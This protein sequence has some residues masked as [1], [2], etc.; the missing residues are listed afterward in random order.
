MSSILSQSLLDHSRFSS[1]LECIGQ[2]ND[3]RVNRRKRHEL[4]AVL[5][6]AVCAMLGGAN[7]W[8]AVELFGKLHVDWL[9]QLVALPYGVPSHDTFNRV[10]AGL[11]HEELAVWLNVWLENVIGTAGQH[12]A[13]DGKILKALNSGNALTIVRAWAKQN[14]ITLA[15][16]RVPKRTNEIRALP[17]VLAQLALR[18]KIVTIDAI[19]TQRH[20]V[21]QIAAQGGDYVLAVK[22]NQS[23]LYWNVKLFLNDLINGEFPRVAHS[24][25]KTYDEGHGRQEL[26]EC[27]ATEAVGWYYRQHDWP[28]LRSI[29]VLQSTRTVKQ[30]TAVTRRY[31]I[32][33]LPAD[34][35]RL[36]TLIRDHWSIENGP[37]WSLDMVFEE[38][39]STIRIGK[40]PQNCAFL[41]TFCYALLA[42]VQDRLSIKNRRFAANANFD[43]L[44]KTLLKLHF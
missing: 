19:G 25:A 2:I 1:L 35:K 28:K 8:L 27:W 3:F 7:S 40:G 34:A 42:N 22:R 31:Y 43:Y 36:L 41:R 6:I 30:K 24:Y 20:I 26:R 16:T 39:R 33:S 29:I 38:D 37:H 18:G 21:T 11:D 44:F 32:S 23:E 17:I 10:F 9:K 15:L 4:T 5:L 12:I 13:I 14:R